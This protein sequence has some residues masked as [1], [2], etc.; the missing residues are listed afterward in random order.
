MRIFNRVNSWLTAVAI[1]CIAAVATFS[2]CT[3]IADYT[4]GEEL[5]PGHQQMFIRY[6]SYKGGM[7]KETDKAA[8]A[9]KVFETRLFRTD[10]VGTTSLGKVYLGH[11]KDSRFGNRK[12]GF[13]GQVLFSK[14]V[15][16]SL[17]FGYRPVYDSMMFV[18]AVDTFAGDTSKPVKYNIYELTNSIVAAGAEDTIFYAN[19]DPRREGAL[20]ADAKP[21]FTF[22]FPDPENGIYTTSTELRLTETEA[23][24]AF[25][26][27]LMCKGKLD[28]NGL[29]NDN[30]VAYESD[31]AFINNFHGLYIE[32][33]E[34]PE[35]EGSIFSFA[36][37]STGI[38]LLGRMR[39]PGHDA[40][41]IA[42]TLNISYL[43]KDEYAEDWGNVSAQSMT[44]DFAGTEVGNFVVDETQDNRDEVAVAYVDGCAG[45]Y[46]ELTFSDEFLNSLREIHG[47]NAEYVSAAINQAALKVY[48]DGS[49]YD[50]TL[51]DPVPMSEKLNSSISRLGLYTDYKTLSPIPDYLYTQESSGVLYYNGYMNRSLACYEMNISSYM[52]ALTNE[53][54]NLEEEADG[55][56][57]YSKLDVPRTIYLAP[58]AYDRFTF[59][60]SII[61]GCDEQTTPATIQ[62][63]LTYTLVK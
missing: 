21:I 26:D 16:D 33:A 38:K 35:G 27:R 19:Y 57:D 17:G 12:F 62:L 28:A 30:V 14:S 13:T 63:E 25:I 18:F 11:Q 61:Q 47:G 55:T 4:L 7:L 1:L 48:I 43:F 29:A 45:V 2:G 3:T 54:L 49:N 44:Y 8:T 56:L 34:T 31:S 52:Q 20:A 6:R 51:I 36:S 50:Y 32:V 15:N 60:R 24:K 40:D 46:T 5:T 9:C 10:S 58:G 22:Q 42:D 59:N 37:K 53:V 41:I 39:N 23:S